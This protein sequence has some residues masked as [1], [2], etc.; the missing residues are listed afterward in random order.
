MALELA[1]Q[2]QDQSKPETERR[3]ALRHLA[4]L[5]G[6]SSQLV[7]EIHS[8]DVGRVAG[9]MVVF[10]ELGLKNFSLEAAAR[11]CREIRFESSERKRWQ[12]A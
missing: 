9:T 4:A 1:R 5:R 8:E 12:A 11:I 3:D 6:E 2:A 7:S 10:G